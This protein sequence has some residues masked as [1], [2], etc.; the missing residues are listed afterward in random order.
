MKKGIISIL[1]LVFVA[2]V[3]AQTGKQKNLYD[4]KVNDIDGKEFDLA[5]LKGKKV[6]IVNVASKCGFTPQYKLLQELYEEYKDTGFVIIGF[7]ANNFR[8]QEP[9]TNK[10]IKEFC[11][12]NYGV[13]FPIMEKISVAGNDQAPIYR[14]LTKKSENGKVDRKVIWNFQKFLIDEEGNLVNVVM[15][16]KSPKSK[17]ILKWLAKN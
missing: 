11:T 16:M 17:V 6:M 2:F 15:P 9:G 4:F 13:T 12:L 5:Q 3:Y 8:G 14:W 1:L 7:P 10:E